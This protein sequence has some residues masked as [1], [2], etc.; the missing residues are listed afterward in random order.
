MFV[1]TAEHQGMAQAIVGQKLLDGW[2]YQKQS[3]AKDLQEQGGMTE[4]GQDGV[5]LHHL[6]GLEPRRLGKL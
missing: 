3:T 4:L 6:S 5:R 2:T 1:L